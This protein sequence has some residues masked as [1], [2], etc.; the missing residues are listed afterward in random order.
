MN[1]SRLRVRGVLVL[2]LVFA[3]GA[4]TGAAGY[5]WWSRGRGFTTMRNDMSGVL[6]QLELTPTQRSAVNV[7]LTRST[8]RTEQVMVEMA[9]RMTALADSLDQELR[10]VLTPAQQQTLDRF[11]QRP[12]FLLKRSQPD[13]RTRI[14]TVGR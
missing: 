7:I 2:V 10:A 3:A 8:P 9:D 13:G 14:D 4:A 11:R 12:L 1:A 6:D 5:G